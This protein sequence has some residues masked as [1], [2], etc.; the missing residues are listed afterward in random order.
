M[1][2][3]KRKLP[4]L[5]NHLQ[6][7]ELKSKKST[8]SQPVEHLSAAADTEDMPSASEKEVNQPEPESITL[9]EDLVPPSHRQRP[10]LPLLWL[11]LVK[12]LQLLLRFMELTRRAMF[13]I[14][15]SEPE[16]LNF[17]SNSFDLETI[18]LEAQEAHSLELPKDTS[19]VEKIEELVV[20]SSVHNDV[21]LS[22]PQPEPTSQPNLGNISTITPESIAKIH[23]ILNYLNNTLDEVVISNDLKAK[24][25]EAA[26]FLSHVAPVEDAAIAKCD[27]AISHLK[28]VKTRGRS[29]EE[30][31]V[32][33]ERALAQRVEN[34]KRELADAQ[35]NLGITRGGLSKIR[36]ANLKVEQSLCTFESSKMYYLKK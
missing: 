25:L 19:K 16:D 18:P 1:V 17:D 29:K 28:H 5:S 9:Q 11:P 20:D 21:P 3:N 32:T 10:Q 23:D 31:V 35:K 34:L 4:M 2:L 33:T 30:E 26:S 22:T 24:L 27:D 36:A 12:Q 15:T 13:S 6:R 14:L 8:S 7:R